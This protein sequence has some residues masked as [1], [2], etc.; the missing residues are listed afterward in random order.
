[1]KKASIWFLLLI[2]IGF[3]HPHG[4]EYH[5]GNMDEDVLKAD[6]SHLTSID[7]LLSPPS[8]LPHHV[9][10]VVPR[11][12][13]L[14]EKL[15]SFASPHATGYLAMDISPDSFGFIKIVMSQSNYLS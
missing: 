6:D 12:I 11:K 5:N 10:S 13:F 7:V 9:D 15:K 14:S 3:Q 2:L 4:L 1:M 8:S